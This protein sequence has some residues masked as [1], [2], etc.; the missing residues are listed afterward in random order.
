MRYE[1][2]HLRYF[3]AV[4]EELNFRRAAE[5]LNLAQP[6]LSRA[7][8]QLEHHVAVRLLNRT[9]RRVELTEAGRVFLDGCRRS[10]ASLEKAAAEARKAGVGEIGHFTVGYTDFAIS[11]V[12]PH[13]L[14]KFRRHY[15]GVTVDLLHRF[16]TQQYDDLDKRMID[17]GFMT[18]PAA[19]PGLA[20]MT[21]QRD[22]FVVVLSEKHPLA[23]RE[24]IPLPM[25]AREPFVVGIASAWKHY[26]R[27]VDALCQSAGFTPRVVQEAFNSEGIFGL[28][29]ANMGLT[30]HVECVRNYYRTGLAIR[31]LEDVDAC[32]PTEMAWFPANTTPVM[33]R[34]IEFVQRVCAEEDQ[35]SL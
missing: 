11:G 18:G 10:M 24:E 16:T 1:L 22:R 27:H 29:A 21:V 15:P 26:H 23:E 8:Q 25:L 20:H 6:A 34:F 4:A 12:L 35:T 31:P 14:E 32:V 28:I 17:F 30:I 13:I 3:I 19:A 33:E 5:R 9:N 2:R 7:I